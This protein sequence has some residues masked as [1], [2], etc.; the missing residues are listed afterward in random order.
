M[1]AE[2]HLIAYSSFPIPRRSPNQKSPTNWRKLPINNQQAKIAT[3]NAAQS[4]ICAARRT[5]HNA[6]FVRK[7]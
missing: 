5:L 7:P 4:R 3:A 6:P 2:R 1:R